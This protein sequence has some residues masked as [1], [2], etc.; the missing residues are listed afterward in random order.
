MNRKIRAV[1]KTE[2]GKFI[3]GEC[4]YLQLYMNILLRI[5]QIAQIGG[6]ITQNW[7]ASLEDLLDSYELTQYEVKAW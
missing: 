4:I 7:L 5:M 1:P 3:I 2:D 6:R